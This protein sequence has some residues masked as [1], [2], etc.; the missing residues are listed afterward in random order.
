MNKEGCKGYAP[1]SH[2]RDDH[3]AGIR[4][5]AGKFPTANPRAAREATAGKAHTPPTTPDM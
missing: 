3:D 2:L 1:A 5:N 4:C